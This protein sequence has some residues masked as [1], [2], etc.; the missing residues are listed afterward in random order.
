MNRIIAYLKPRA[1]DCGCHAAK[2]RHEQLRSEIEAI[3]AASL[4]TIEFFGPSVSQLLG[5]RESCDED[6]DGDGLTTRLYLKVEA[7]RV[8]IDADLREYAIR[9]LRRIAGELEC[10]A[11]LIEEQGGR[12]ER[13]QS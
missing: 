6:D 1:S 3:E 4:D 9:E 5:F 11:D 12:T 13:G 8:S 7:D 2:Q 10:A